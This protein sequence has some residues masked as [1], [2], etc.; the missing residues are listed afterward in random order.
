MRGGC[1]DYEA[2]RQKYLANALDL[3]PPYYI[4]AGSP[5]KRQ[6]WEQDHRQWALRY[7]DAQA[8]REI[9]E[10]R[11]MHDD[12]GDEPLSDDDFLAVLKSL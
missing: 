3:E 11:R 5:E 12:D 8:R 1:F 9:E 4:R 7:A 2:L 6:R 10:Y